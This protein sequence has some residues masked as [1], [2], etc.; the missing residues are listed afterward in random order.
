MK[1]LLVTGGAGFI[2][3]NFVE[4]AQGAYDV[5][6]IDKLTYCG[7]RDNLSGLDH[8]FIKGDINDLGSLEGFDIIVH[9]AAETH[10]DNS[11]LRSDD[12]IRTNVCGTWNLLE[13][14]RKSE[15]VGQFIVI[16]TDEVYGDIPEGTSSAEKDPF[17]PS[18]PYSA[19][20]ASADLMAQAYSRTYGLPIKIV[21]PSNCFGPRQFPEKL[22]PFFVKRV[23]DGKPMPVYGHGRQRRCW[24]HTGDVCRAIWAVADKGELGAAYNVGG[25]EM[26]NMSIAAAI[27]GELGG[28]IEHV[29]DRPGHDLRYCVDDSRVRGLGW[30]PVGSFEDKLSQTILHYAGRA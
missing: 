12:F 9:M 27:M 11:I 16:S 7:S 10:V 1:R 3:S 28:E 19:S 22:I 4:S 24:V 6:V 30:E 14:L 25:A 23:M 5:T 13:A 29:Q 21:R 17:H 15:D 18:N 8:E 2:G 26:D 20:K